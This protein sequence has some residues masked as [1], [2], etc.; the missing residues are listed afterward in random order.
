MSRSLSL[1]SIL[2]GTFAVIFTPIATIYVIAMDCAFQP[3]GCHGTTAVM[4]ADFLMSPSVIY[5]V[6][7]I[8]I[9][10][11]LIW[12]GMHHRRTV[13]R[14]KDAGENSAGTGARQ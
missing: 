5:P 4:M 2:I 9:G 7:P 11:V 10:I 14:Q 1:L 13:Y 6:I 8:V 12:L 3:L